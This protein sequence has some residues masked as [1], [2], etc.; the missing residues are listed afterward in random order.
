VVPS[1]ASNASV[2]MVIVVTLSRA[3]GAQLK[4]RSS[5]EV[6]HRE[7]CILSSLSLAYRP[8]T[9]CREWVKGLGAVTESLPNG[10]LKP[11]LGVLQLPLQLL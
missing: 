8:A 9:G 6:L 1:V 3:H 4:G 5:A 7:L 11:G 10:Q 2:M